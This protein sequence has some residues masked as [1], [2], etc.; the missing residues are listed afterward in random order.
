MTPSSGWQGSEQVLEMRRRVLLSSQRDD[1]QSAVGFVDGF[2]DALDAYAAAIAEAVRRE[3]ADE[4]DYSET[5]VREM[6]A[7]TQ[8]PKNH[9]L[10]DHLRT[11]MRRLHFTPRVPLELDGPDTFPVLS[12][13]PATPAAG[14]VT[15]EMVERAAIALCWATTSYNGEPDKTQWSF[16]N[17]A[18]RDD[19]RSKARVALTAALTAHKGKPDAE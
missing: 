10:S 15:A 19:F 18:V 2:L 14:S 17:E 9:S 1:G 16:G 8:C 11:M 5:V 6:E 3:V 7:L 12:A 4:T 13:E